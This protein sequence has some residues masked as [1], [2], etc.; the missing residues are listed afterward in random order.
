MSNLLYDNE[1]YTTNAWSWKKRKHKEYMNHHFDYKRELGDPESLQKLRKTHV[2]YELQLQQVEFKDGIIT[3]TTLITEHVEYEPLE[4]LARWMKNT[5]ERFLDPIWK[6]MMTTE[7]NVRPHSIAYLTAP[8]TTDA[9]KL[10]LEHD[11]EYRAYGRQAV[12]VR[13]VELGEALKKWREIDHHL[14]KDQGDYNVVRKHQ[15][16]E[17][18]FKAIKDGRRFTG[19]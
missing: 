3:A 6:K 17:M 18:V 12:K 2:N 8:Y 13:L 5:D 9:S 14:G 10:T 15:I 19:E 16:G 11:K 7:I 4:R 1:R